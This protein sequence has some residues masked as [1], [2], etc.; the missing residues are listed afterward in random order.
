MDNAR[1]SYIIISPVRN[2]AKYIEKT[3]LSVA[4]QTI[5][6]KKWLIVDDGSTDKTID[7]VTGFAKDHNFIELISRP[8]NDIEVSSLDRIAKAAPP[9][10]FNYGLDYLNNESFDFVV[11]LDGDLSFNSDYF[12]QLFIEFKKNPK[13][14]IASGLASFPRSGGFYTPYVP[15]EHVL[16]CSKV[17][18]RECF[19][20]IDGVEEVLGW[21]TID[22]VKAQMRGWQ[23]QHF[24]DIRLI[25]WRLMGTRAGYVRGKMRHGFTNYYLGYYPLYMLAR[26]VKRMA[27]RPYVIPGILLGMGYLR[28]YLLRAERFPD[29]EFRA[30]LRETQVRQLKKLANRK[31][32]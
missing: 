13:L 30:Y 29:N 32:A 21:D 5:Q 10:T 20:D 16:G 25:H 18:R 3:L 9:K 27:E 6:P 14:G 22:E 8:Q 12:A 31:A 15:K 26:V 17:Y 28:G 7:I 1:P 2:E 23:T 4:T 24:S 11:K 19:L